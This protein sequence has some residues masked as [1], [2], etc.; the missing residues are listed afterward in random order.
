MQSSFKETKIKKRDH[1][2]SSKRRKLFHN[3]KRDEEPVSMETEYKKDYLNWGSPPI[4][5]PLRPTS[6]FTIVGGGNFM[7]STMY[8]TD[9][10]EKLTLSRKK[11][12]VKRKK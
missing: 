10:K 12:A 11:D 9:Y 6:A 3:R 4:I 7:S 5:E 2:E 8:K 1:Q